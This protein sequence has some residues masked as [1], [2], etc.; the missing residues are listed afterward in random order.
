MYSVDSMLHRLLSSILLCALISTGR[1]QRLSVLAERPDWTRL[2]AFQGTI[3]REEFTRLLD[4]VY[5]PGGAAMGLVT[6]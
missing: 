6:A 4:Q 1:A 3:T 2:E 5:A